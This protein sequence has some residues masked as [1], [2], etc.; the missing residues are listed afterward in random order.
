MHTDRQTDNI[1][2]FKKQRLLI[3]PVQKEFRNGTVQY[4]STL[5]DLLNIT[6]YRSLPPPPGSG[7]CDETIDF[8]KNH[9][10][11]QKHCSRVEQ[12]IH[13]RKE[14]TSVLERLQFL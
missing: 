14:W 12:Y 11:E 3:S 1:Q 4:I 9:G 2:T 5:A 7:E 8:Y 10:E 6:Y 13:P